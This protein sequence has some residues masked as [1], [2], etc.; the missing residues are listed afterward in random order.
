MGDKIIFTNVENCR[1]F[2]VL[3]DEILRIADFCTE[4]FDCTGRIY[5]GRVSNVV[6]NLNAAFVEYEKG[7]QGFLPFSSFGHPVQEI[8]NEIRIPVQIKTA[9]LKTKEPVLT[10]ELS[11]PGIYCVVTNTPSGIHFSKKINHV[12]RQEIKDYL[13]DDLDQSF[14]YI[15]RSNVLSLNPSDLYLL[16]EEMQ[17]LSAQMKDIVL[18]LSSRA[19]YSCLYKKSDFLVQSLSRVDFQQVDAIIT[20]SETEFQYM[21]R[22][23]P[24]SLSDCVSLYQDSFSLSVLY[25]L[26]AK[27]HNMISRTVWLKSG[28]YLVVDYTEALTVIDVNSGKNIKKVSKAALTAVTNKEAAEVIP[29]L[30]SA[31][32]MSGIILVDFINTNKKEDENALLKILKQKMSLD[33]NKA[34]VVD[35][36][37]LGLVEITRQKKDTLLISKMKEAGIYEAVKH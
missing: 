27:L 4:S 35:V 14:S 7:K 16:K 26:K 34:D 13:S 17:S 8:K 3:R 28:G 36:T 10:A 29:Y 30:I 31:N 21:K 6:S 1:G 24:Q 23:L 33:P 18:R 19:F 5:I 9:P 2:F 32:N 15:I 25:E 22:I 20:D 12:L 11:L 37:S